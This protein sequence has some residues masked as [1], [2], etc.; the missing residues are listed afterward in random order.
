LVWSLGT[1]L[2]ASTDF[3]VQTTF[4]VSNLNAPHGLGGQI[5]F[6][7]LNS[8]TTGDNRAG[9]GSGSYPFDIATV[10]W[11]PNTDSR[12]SPF[13]TFT[14]TV[15]QSNNGSGYY[16]RLLFPSGAESYLGQNDGTHFE[17]NSLAGFTQLT[18]TLTYQ[19]QSSYGPILTLT[20]ADSSGLLPINAIG[21][22]AGV[23]GGLDGNITTIQLQLAGS[24][25]FSVNEFGLTLWNDSFYP[26]TDVASSADL[27][28]SR[29]LVTDPSSGMY[30][31][32][33]PEPSCFVLTTLGG[34]G[35]CGW[36]LLG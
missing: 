9:N 3:E 15:I 35:L 27:T 26:A 16:S 36:H 25:A 18:A 30:I 4:S 11:F 32:W 23:P 10:D 2:D 24:T 5:S 22:S 14:P 8:V 13:Q 19:T 28:F 33:I 34:M 29:I 21:G 1:T 31:E 6:G 7:L 12:F 17:P 20:L